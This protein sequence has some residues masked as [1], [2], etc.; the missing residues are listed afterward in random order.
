MAMENIDTVYFGGK[1]SNS[2]RLR[3]SNGKPELIMQ[4]A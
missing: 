1:K 3:S 4:V 2:M